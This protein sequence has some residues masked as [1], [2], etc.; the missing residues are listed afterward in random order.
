MK[1]PMIL[2]ATAVGKTQFLVKLAS[3]IP[4]EVVSVDSRQIYR[5]MDIGTA[6]PTREELSKLKHHVIDVVD[7]DEDFNVFEYRKIALKAM[8]EIVKKGRIPVFAGGSGLYAE[9]LMKGIVE[10]VPRNDKVREALKTLEVNAPGSLRKLLE[11]VDHEAYEKIHPNDLKRTIRYLEVFFTTGK[12]LTSLQKIHKC[13][14][15]FTVIILERDRRELAERIENRVDK[16]I[17]S[18]LI[19]E[20]VRLKEMGYTRELNSQQTIGYAEIWS[21]LEGEVT[22]ERATELIKRNTRRFARRQIIWFRRYKDAKRISLSETNEN[23][24]LSLLKEDIL[25][26]WGGKYG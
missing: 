10:N 7:P 12:T 24:I 23:D 9:T 25:N 6:K 22:L 11:K 16:M 21:Y 26:V 19:E 5:Y 18:G 8:D 3:L 1:I 20:V 2:G 4:I 17:E 13:S 15:Q 14:N